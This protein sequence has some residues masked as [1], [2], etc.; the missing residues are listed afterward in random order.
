[1]KPTSE[2]SERWVMESRLA[3]DFEAWERTLCWFL[4]L[5]VV[6]S[7]ILGDEETGN[8]E[9]SIGM[10]KN[11]LQQACSIQPKGQERDNLTRQKKFKQNCSTPDKRHRKKN[12]TMFLLPPTKASE[13][14]Y[15]Y[16]VLWYSYEACGREGQVR[17]WPLRS[18]PSPPW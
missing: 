1:M 18:A 13:A 6:S 15:S 5:F 9:I 14:W 2:D 17:N 12:V 3:G 7:H 16:E 10:D 8:L 11:V 4:C